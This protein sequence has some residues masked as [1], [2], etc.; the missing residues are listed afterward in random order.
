MKSKLAISLT[1]QNNNL[2]TALPPME[3]LVAMVDGWTKPSNIY[4]LAKLNQLLAILTLEKMDLALTLMHKVSP[5]S[6]ISLMLHPTN[7]LHSLM[8]L[9]TDQSQLLFKQELLPSCPTLQESSQ[10]P[11]AELLWIM[12]FSLLDME[13]KEDKTT[14]SSRTHGDHHG[15]RADM[16]DLRKTQILAQEHVA[17]SR[18]LH[19]QLSETRYFQSQ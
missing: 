11:N 3:T 5:M 13:P 12:E 4:K 1:C 7:Q 17:S 8:L 19:T 9:P 18:L 15:E 10:R 6:L 16:S 14:G 2:L